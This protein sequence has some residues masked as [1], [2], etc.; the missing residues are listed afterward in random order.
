MDLLQKIGGR[1]FLMALIATGA[2]VFMEVGTSKGLSVNLAGLL[3]GLVGVFSAANYKTTAKHFDMKAGVGEN[4]D[5][6]VNSHKDL[7]SKVA[8]LTSIAKASADSDNVKKLVDL[9]TDINTGISQ[10]QATSGQIG[11]AV[12]NMNKEVQQ[13]KRAV[14]QPSF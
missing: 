3:V 2:A 9:L 10:V 4:D 5:D 8:E 12:V 7:S 6:L 14:S 11:Q 13:V 1:K